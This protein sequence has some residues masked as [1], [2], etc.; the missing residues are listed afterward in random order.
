MEWGEGGD[1]DAVRELRIPGVMLSSLPER[2]FNAVFYT[3]DAAGEGEVVINLGP[4]SYG[5]DVGE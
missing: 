2:R 1:L 5:S 4:Y 3:K